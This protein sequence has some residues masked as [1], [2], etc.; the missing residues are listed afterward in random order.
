MNSQLNSSKS[1][2]V[3]AGRSPRR[4]F[5]V[6]SGRL[7][8]VTLNSAFDFLLPM[9]EGLEHLRRRAFRFRTMSLNFLRDKETWGSRCLIALEFRSLCLKSADNDLFQCIK[10]REKLK[11]YKIFGNK[12]S[13]L[14]V[15]HEVA[16]L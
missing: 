10:F 1:K 16:L 15:G 3:K 6:F 12:I 11:L 5:K 2:G 8:C 14:V 9:R 4:L 7:G 13:S